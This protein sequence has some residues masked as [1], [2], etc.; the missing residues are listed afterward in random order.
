[1]Q[2]DDSTITLRLHGVLQDVVGLHTLPVPSHVAD[3]TPRDI[4]ELAVDL[5]P[6][7]ADYR[8]SVAFGTK[9]EV[10]A[11]DRTIPPSIRV[12]EV[13]PPVSGG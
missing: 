2:D 9:Q 5:H 11:P 8:E 12:I 1:M 7:L 10:I 6:A 13:L 4:F 3:C